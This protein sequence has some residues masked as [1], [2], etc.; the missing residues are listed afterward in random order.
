MFAERSVSVV[1]VLPVSTPL[2]AGMVSW[3]RR[4]AFTLIE[5]LVVMAIISVLAGLLL[6]AVQQAR[7]S[8]R[9]V[10][11]KNNLKQLMLALHN[12]ADVWRGALMPVDVYNW[13]IP[14]GTPGGEGRYWFGEVDASFNLD[15]TRGFLAPYMENQRASYNCP[16]FGPGHVTAM[17]F[18]QMT[19][20]YAY[21]YRYLGPGLQSTIDWMTLTV[22]PTKPINFR[23]QDVDQ[24]T[25]TIV[26]ADAAAVNCLNWPSC[27]DNSFTESWYLEPPSGGFPNMHFRHNGVANVAFLDG[28]VESRMRSWVDPPS[29]T[30]APQVQEM[31]KRLLGY[32]G[33]DDAYYQNHKTRPLD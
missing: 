33:D 18:N 32:V 31:K 25:R 6:P 10:Q 14:V 27:T 9:T 7:E 13:T 21:N 19:S 28:H 24:P 17:E 30:A 5:L 1:R 4:G 23:L 8:A 2:S 22:D 20:G 16:D 26:F 11:C 12:Y 15:F 29:W 3:R